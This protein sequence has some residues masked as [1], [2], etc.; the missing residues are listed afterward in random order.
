V[1]D[2][3]TAELVGTSARVLDA[4]LDRPHGFDPSPHVQRWAAIRPQL[5]DLGWFDLLGDP[6][7]GG[8]GLPPA[9]AVRLLRLAGSHLVP[10]PVVEAV[11]TVPWLRAQ[12]GVEGDLVTQQGI[13]FV[14]VDPGSALTVTGGRLQGTA[15]CVLGA[16]TTETLLVQAVTDEGER[17]V[18]LPSAHPGVHVEQLRGADPCQPTGHVAFDCALEDGHWVRSSD[19]QLPARFRAWT[20][21]GDAAYLAGIT[22]R[23]LS[24]G[25]E[26]ALTREQFGRPIGSFQAVQ[27]LLAGVAVTAR[28]LANVVDFAATE[29]GTVDDREATLL[30]ATA[31]AR[32]STAA[33]QACETVLQVLGGIGFTVEHPLHHYLKRA[34]SLSARHG[35]PAELN[36]LAGRLVLSPS[37]TP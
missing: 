33:V 6:A 18:V 21:L 8:L 35:S 9:L 31:K 10:G 2:T 12:P 19:A 24:F 5:E 13:S 22:A 15:P 7:S 16:G 26:H 37:E 20:R 32:A 3:L 14:T 25:V 23:V 1:P 11:L 30:A 36:L 28:S 27:H 17:L 34:L 29:L 4:A